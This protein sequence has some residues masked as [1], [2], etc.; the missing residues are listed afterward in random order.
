VFGVWVRPNGLF[1]L[2]SKLSDRFV[3]QTLLGS[4]SCTSSS[5][6]HREEWQADEDWEKSRLLSASA[7]WGTGGYLTVTPRQGLKFVKIEDKAFSS[8][9]SLSEI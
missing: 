4:L 9:W 3:G 7:N 1:G 5:F 8:L 2:R 6:G